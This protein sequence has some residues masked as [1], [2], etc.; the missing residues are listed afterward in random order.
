MQR[1]TRRIVLFGATGYTGRL[2]AEHLA[3]TGTPFTIAGRN[4]A[5]LADLASRLPAEVETVHADVMRQNSVFE[6]VREGDVLVT[7][8]GPFVKWGEPAIRAAIAAGAIYVDTTG[9]PQWIR[10]V[11]EEFSGPA[12][13]KGAGLLT[14]SAYDYVPGCL[15]GALAVHEAG[16][17]AVRVDVG[18]YGIGGDLTSWAS[19][20]TRESLVGAGVEPGFAYRGGRIVEERAAARVRDFPVLGKERSAFSIGGAEHYTLP[21]AFPQLREVNVY[22]GMLG[23]LSR[24]MQVGSLATDLVTRLPGVRGVMRAAGERLA[25][26]APDPEPGTT[27]DT[28]SYVAAVA[29]D[30]DGDPV[31]EVHLAGADAYAFTAAILSWIARRAASAGVEGAGALSPV[32]A[33]GLEALEQGCAEAGLLRVES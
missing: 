10:R 29:Y 23:P 9:E 24:A 8:V 5:K 12:R 20:G 31:K 30:A 4:R 7:T 6:M 16:E 32:Q 26:L 25:A 15:A 28:V 18:Y 3:A 21:A 14:A 2:T 1:V 19:A 13:A 33:F 22:V 27:Q 11:F 17:Q